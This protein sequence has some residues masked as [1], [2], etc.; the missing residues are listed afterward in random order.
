MKPFRVG[1]DS[2]SLSPLDLTPF[3]VL[4]WVVEHGGE[5]VQFS[6]VNLKNGQLPDRAFLEDL[7]RYARER[8][9]YL[10]W[11]GGQHIPFDVKTWKELDLLPIN[12][13]A[14]E[15]AKILGTPVIRSCSG[16]LMR[17]KDESPPTET[18]LRAMARV[19]KAQK[20]LFVD[21]NT[22][23]AIELHFE[24]TTFELLRLFEMCEAEPGGYLGI[25]LDTMNLLTMLEDPVSGTERILPWVVATHI[26]DGGLLLLEE[27]LLSFTA[28]AG[29]G[30][31]DFQKIL[32]MLSTLDRTINLSVEDHGG[33][34]TIPIFDP[35]FLARFPDLTMAELDRLLGLAREGN[36]RI[37]K[38][39]ITPIDRT[40]WP[41]HCEVRVRK[42]IQNIKGIINESLHPASK[43]G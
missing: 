38:Q 42:G 37:Q 9:L 1:I 16:G 15:Q 35:L 34:F 18:L 36:I 25:C 39:L 41:E 17:W 30:L 6:E 12:R 33:S 20:K 26:K 43:D 13:T 7:A 28:E 5:G 29:S 27:C 3:E 19:L 8:N 22:V 23:L 11:G 32:S 14:V 2:Y 31:V 21:S 40:D 24:F 4:D 10:E